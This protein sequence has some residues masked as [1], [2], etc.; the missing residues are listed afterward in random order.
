MTVS[1]DIANL[2]YD[3]LDVLDYLSFMNKYTPDMENQF[4]V[5]CF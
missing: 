1:I 5:G 4:R 3:V 2:D